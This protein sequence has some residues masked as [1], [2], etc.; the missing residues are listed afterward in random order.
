MYSDD[1][2]AVVLSS[3]EYSDV[4]VRNRKEK[5]HSRRKQIVSL[6][7]HLANRGLKNE[8]RTLR[9][10]ARHNPLKNFKML[11]SSRT[12]YVDYLTMRELELLKLQKEYCIVLS[13]SFAKEVKKLLSSINT[14]I[15]KLNGYANISSADVY[16]LV[17]KGYDCSLTESTLIKEMQQR[18]KSTDESEKI[19]AE[20]L[21]PVV[22]NKPHKHS[23]EQHKPSCNQQHTNNK[24][25][26]SMQ[27]SMQQPVAINTEASP[28]GRVL[29]TNKI[30]AVVQP[31]I[32]QTCSI[33]QEIVEMPNMFVV[34]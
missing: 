19:L 10:Q 27:Q 12:E 17:M 26:P 33:P 1:D 34:L 4:Y 29:E 8:A 14:K 5:I 21:S 20:C 2:D 7:I 31:I 22:L 28:S 23:I 11:Q 25:I 24:L 15:D 16:D 9:K 32:T 13:S 3:V 6:S 30:N 18:H